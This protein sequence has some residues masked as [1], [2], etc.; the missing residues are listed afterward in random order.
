M[1]GT[2]LSSKSPPCVAASTAS[3]AASG[4]IAVPAL[5]RNERR[6][7]AP[8]QRAR[9]CR[10][11]CVRSAPSRSTPQPSA[12]SAS[13][14]TRVSSESSRSWIVGA[15]FAQAG[16][17]QHAV[18][19]ALRARQAHRA[20][21]AAQAAARS[22]S[23]MS[24]MAGAAGSRARGFSSCRC[25]RAGCPAA[26][27][28]APPRRCGSGLR[29]R[30]RCRSCMTCSIASSVWRKRA[31]C[32]RISSRLAIRMSR[33]IVG[34]LAAMRVKSRKPG[35]ASDRKSRPAGW[36]TTRAEVG[37]G[38]QVRQVAHRRRRRRRGS[39]ASCA[40]PARRWRPTRRWPSA[41]ARAWSAAAASGS[42]GGR[43]TARRRRCCD[44]R[45]LPCRRSG[46]PARRR[47][48]RSFSTRRAASTTSRLVEPTSMNSTPGSTR[49]RMA[50][51]VASVADTGTASSTMSEPDDGQQR[52]LGRHVDHAHALGALGGRGRLAVADHALDQP[53]ALE[54]QRERAAHQAASDDAELVEHGDRSAPV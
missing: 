29:A 11:R 44:A 37:E 47:R 14:M 31:D 35:P 25:R 3:A 16:Q 24:Y 34:S 4:R 1:R 36:L 15:A 33:Q 51:N 2:P 8:A 38:Q 32:L 6:P 12:R 20:G 21:R 42:P 26:S 18:G 13:S 22:R 10:P 19:D 30:R 27:R 43:R 45:R 49:W 52:R 23:G 5:P 50:L 40:A 39:R 28:R 48:T 54:R 17:Q 53:G 7:R 9:R 46:A 41:P